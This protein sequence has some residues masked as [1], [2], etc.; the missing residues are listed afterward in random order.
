MPWRSWSCL[1]IDTKGLY[2]TA[3]TPNPTKSQCKQCS[4]VIVFHLS[5]VSHIFCLHHFSLNV[6]TNSRIDIILSLHP[7]TKNK[8]P[9]QTKTN[10]TTP[11]RYTE[12]KTLMSQ[13]LLHEYLC[14]IGDTIHECWLAEHSSVIVTEYFPH[15]IAYSTFIPT[16]LHCI[17]S[18][19]YLI[20]PPKS[21]R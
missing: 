2:R 16:A 19:S 8:N 4:Y 14:E 21:I 13:S 12:K 20:P 11:L 1:H 9:P 18:F 5:L 7:K 6:Y 17:M 10:Q 3:V 15:K